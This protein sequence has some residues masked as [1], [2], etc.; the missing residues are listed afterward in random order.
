MNA[1][2]VFHPTF[3]TGFLLDSWLNA[4]ACLT[5]VVA[6]VERCFLGVVVCRV[7]LLVVGMFSESRVREAGSFRF[8]YGERVTGASSGKKR[9]GAETRELVRGFLGVTALSLK[10]CEEGAFLKT[11]GRS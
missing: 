5:G 10:I 3:E 1:G 8:L 7:V 2:V 11:A 4:R 6:E 9:G